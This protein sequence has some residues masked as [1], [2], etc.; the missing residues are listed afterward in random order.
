[1]SNPYDTEGRMSAFVPVD[2]RLDGAYPLEIPVVDQVFQ[3]NKS[4]NFAPRV[5]FAWNVRGD[6]RTALR[7]GV[8]LF[9][10]QI[11]NEFRRAVG[12][13]AP[14]WTSVRVNNPPFP[15]S[16]AS[17][18]SG[19]AGALQPL[20]IHQFPEIP[21][22]TQY[23]L[24]LE[25]ALGERAV[26]AVA[27]VGSRGRN[28]ARTGN[29]QI[30]VP[31][32]NASGRLEVENRLVTPAYSS[33]AAFIVFDANSWYDSLQVEFEQRPAFGLR[34]KAAFT[35]SKAVDEG[36]DNN[37]APHGQS[38][39]A[40]VLSDHTFNRGPATHDVPKRFVFNWSYELPFGTHDG[41][42]GVLLNK[43]QLAG[44]F[45]AQGG[46]PF[47]A[48]LGFSRSWPSGEAPDRPDLAAGASTNPVLGGPDLYFDPT[49]FVLPPARTLGTV[50]VNT[51]RGPGL[52]LL[53]V[54]LLKVFDVFGSRSVEFR[55]EVFNLLN[56]ANFGIPDPILFNADGSRRGAA[57]RISSTQTTA[58][59]IQFSVK[60]VF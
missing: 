37:S 58:R 11:E 53:D 41:A 15:N 7:G 10:A 46:F 2:S 9:Y 24:R 23:N 27:Y 55:T 3:E 51:L 30:P 49:A 5:G 13:A 32:E 4:G 26:A 57:G 20:G 48:Q 25:Q 54:S 56:R 59:E 38:D 16:G 44:I 31:F 50:G 40:L 1:M 19:T 52:A 36:V 6:G 33:N 47:T 28:Q 21:V 29:P 39:L 34:F 42:A 12:A 45:Q 17:L 43:W 18:A 14:F 60:F 35:W 8:G 22:T